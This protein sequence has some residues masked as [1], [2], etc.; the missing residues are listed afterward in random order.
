MINLKYRKEIILKDG[1]ACLLKNGEESDGAAA[2]DSF[3]LAHRQTDFLLTYPEEN[4][5]S[6]GEEAEYL[7]EKSDSEREIEILA[8]VDGKVVATA[9]I[10]A[11]GKQEKIRHRAEFGVSVDK[12]FWGL[13]IGTALISACIECAKKAGY[14]QIELEVVSDN[15]SA[16]RLYNKFGFAEFGR[17]P[18]GFKSRISGYMP[19]IY[20]RKEL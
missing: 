2:L 17:N 7:K 12:N 5:F 9:G 1:R 13:G 6:A 16:I 15:Q 4:T 14:S 18:R 8:V 3:I 20:M 10:E 19:L 11:K